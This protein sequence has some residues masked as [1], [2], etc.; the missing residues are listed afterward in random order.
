[1]AKAQP[2]A[3]DLWDSTDAAVSG[4]IRQGTGET[5]LAGGPRC[6]RESKSTCIYRLGQ[7]TK[8]AEPGAAREW[9]G[10]WDGPCGQPWGWLVLP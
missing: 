4:T 3:L 1:M 9:R 10:Y 8:G 7:G 6:D 5:W 2:R